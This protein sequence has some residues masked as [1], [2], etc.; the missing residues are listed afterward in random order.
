[1]VYHVPVMVDEVVRGVIVDPE[2]RII[3]YGAQNGA[4]LATT[5]GEDPNLAAQVEEAE[6]EMKKIREERVTSSNDHGH[7]TAGEE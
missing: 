2:G 6:A 7:G 1:M 5:Y 3:D 4:L